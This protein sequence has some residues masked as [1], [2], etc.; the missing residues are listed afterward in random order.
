MKIS[1]K[2]YQDYSEKIIVPHTLR[3]IPKERYLVYILLNN[4]HAM[5]VGQGK[6]N[7]ARV[8]F[9]TENQPPTNH[10]KAMSVRLMNIYGR[11]NHFERFILLCASEA[12]SKQIERDLHQQIGGNSTQIPEY[13]LSELF[14][15][16]EPNSI[17]A[18]ILKI[19]L[20]SSY[21]GIADLKKWRREGILDDATWGVIAERLQF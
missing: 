16:L 10:I 17:P 12:E 3:D 4:G 21:N 18:I 2:L 13:I 7:R 1:E 19:A 20:N 6:Q 8:I 11:D 15:G 5:I 14:K 9:D